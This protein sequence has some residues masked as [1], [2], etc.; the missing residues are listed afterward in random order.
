MT[1]VA[2][3]H[4]FTHFAENYSLSHVVKEQM[5]MLTEHDVETHFVT[6]NNFKGSVPSN[7]ET[8]AVLPYS[9]KNKILKAKYRQTCP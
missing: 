7:V 9:N 6:S 2:I 1:S 3:Y 5:L 8:H 4:P